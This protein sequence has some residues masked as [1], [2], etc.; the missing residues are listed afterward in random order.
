[1]DIF[2]TGPAGD[3]DG[4]LSKTTLQKLVSFQ[5]IQYRV[6]IGIKWD[7]RYGWILGVRVVNSMDEKSRSRFV[8]TS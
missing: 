7:T 5:R 4:T 2:L 1:V 8:L 3:V 6:Q